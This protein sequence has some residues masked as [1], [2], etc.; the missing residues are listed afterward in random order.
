VDQGINPIEQ[1]RVAKDA[2]KEAQ[3]QTFQTIAERYIKAHEPE[4]GN[5]KHAAQWTA[6]LTAYAY[7]TLKDKPVSSIGVNDVLAVLE[8]IWTEK[9]ETAS[10]VRGRLEAVLGYA[11]ALKLR[12]TENPARW[13]GNLDHLLP[14]RGDIAEVEH[15][16]AVPWAELPGVYA[17]L[18]ESR[19]L[20]ALCLRFL[21]LTAVRS[22]EARSA[23]WAEIDMDAKV[24]TVPAL[25]MKGRKTKKREH[26]VPLSAPA[27]AIL[28]EMAQFGTAPDKLVFP[29]AVKGKPLSDV[30]LNK[31]LRAAGAVDYV[32][33]GLRSTFR[34]WAAE[35]TAYPREVAESA[36]AH[37]NKDKSEAAYL[38]TDHL[39]QRRR[40]MDDWATYATTPAAPAG[41]VVNIGKARA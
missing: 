32:V 3:G 23:T 29:G 35:R 25:R 12:S 1:R 19:G 38:R 30:A 20:S 28:G 5:T 21:I 31:A 8:S 16:P 34:D 9:P 36:L 39:E 18:C 27:L 22:N 11:A 37:V 14:K 40:L 6:T 26:R 17:K 4:W 13:R 15:H 10:R 24:W 33:H 41:Q 7:P 2:A